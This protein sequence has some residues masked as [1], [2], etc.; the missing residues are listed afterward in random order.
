MLTVPMLDI[1]LVAAIVS[2]AVSLLIVVSQGWH[3][4]HSL[5]HDLAGVQKFH[6]TPVPRVGGIA[7]AAGMAAA[8]G[9]CAFSDP[10]RFAHGNVIG[11]VTLLLASVPAFAAGLTEDLTKRVPVKVRLAATMSSALMASWLLGATVHEFDIWGVDLLLTITP[12]AVVATAIVVA[13]GSNAINI[14]NGFNGLACSVVLIMS[15]ALG[16]LAWRAGDMF[17]TELALLGM[18]ATLGFVLVN[19]PKGKLFMGDGG[20]YFLGFWVAEIAILLL[21]RNPSINSWQVL[22]ICAYPVIE[23]LY[24]IYRR[25]FVRK[26]SPGAADGLHL[27][28][29]IYR[30]VVPRLMR[31]DGA[32]PWLR[33]A[34][35]ACLLGPCIGLLALISVLAGGKIHSAA[36]IVGMQVLLYV[37]VYKRLVRGSWGRSRETVRVAVG[38]QASS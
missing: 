29:L 19:Y 5:D 34:A 30:R 9:F 33:N 8:M 27:H 4:K 31:C 16:Y 21:I 23:V 32:I 24:S 36:A 28:T 26:M 25:K 37:A 3:G 15:A 35:V 14:I 10:G 17:V 38:G 22:S 11:A 2:C 12:I 13:G 7:V 1:V 6:A 18:G 20:A